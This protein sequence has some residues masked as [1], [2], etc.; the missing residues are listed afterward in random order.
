MKFKMPA[1]SQQNHSSSN[2]KQC[3]ELRQYLS[4]LVNY[5]TNNIATKWH[6]SLYLLN[7]MDSSFGTN[8][9]LPA[10]AYK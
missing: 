2:N 3:N 10:S 9:R 1:C 6:F 4:E 7:G 5:K 8:P